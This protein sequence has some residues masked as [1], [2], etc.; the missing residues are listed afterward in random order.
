MYIIL[1]IK[2]SNI[3]DVFTERCRQLNEMLERWSVEN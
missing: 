3:F 1:F 2:K